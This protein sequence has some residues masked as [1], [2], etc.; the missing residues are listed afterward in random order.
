MPKASCTTFRNETVQSDFSN[1]ILAG[2][3][4]LYK[5]DFCIH[6]SFHKEVHLRSMVSIKKELDSYNGEKNSIYLAD[7]SVGNHK[8]YKNILALLSAYKHLS[9]SM[10]IRADQI[11]EDFIQIIKKVNIDKLYI[12]LESFNDLFL[13]RHHKGETIEKIKAA[14]QKLNDNHIPFHLSLILDDEFSLT[15]LKN[16]LDSYHPASM[17]FHFYIPYP[18]TIGYNPEK[19]WFENKYWPFTISN[20][21]SNAE[22]LKKEIAEFMRYPLNQYHTITSH[23][24]TQTFAIIQ[25]R[26]EEMEGLL[27]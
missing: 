21:T 5:C 19:K 4:C 9:F 8:F 13:S 22:L 26:I 27:K 20:S 23:D 7:P 17:S 14:L 15:K 25:K 11:T 1:V 6:S 24:H 10:N 2:R 16:L 3:G 12:G 18:G